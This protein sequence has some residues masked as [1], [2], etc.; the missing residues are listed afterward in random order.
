MTTSAREY[1]WK[2]CEKIDG[3]MVNAYVEASLDNEHPEIL[4]INSTWGDNAVDL[5]PAVKA[6]E[7]VT[8]LE[9]VPTDT[10]TTDLQFNRE[11]GGVD[12]ISGDDLSRI[13]SM[14]KL[15]DVDQTTAPTDGDIYIYD[16]DT[17]KFYTFNL[18]AAL[19]D[20]STLVSNL[21]TRVQNLENNLTAMGN[22]VTSLEQN[23]QT[24]NTLLTKP[25]GIPDDAVVAWG[26]RN[27]IF[28]VSNTS[29]TDH[30][31]F[32]HDPSTTLI[33]DTYFS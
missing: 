17:N 21:T 14:A 18:T 22:R 10:D 6:A 16:G 13:I 26:N 7:T 27:S 1:N 31:I 3:R 32:T 11:D 12:C 4:N 2:D 20:I 24:V 25:S 19:G 33:D 23:M 15:K 28:D 29:S 5:T 30:G 9:L 8:S